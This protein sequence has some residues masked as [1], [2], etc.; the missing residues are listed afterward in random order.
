MKMKKVISLML[1]GAFML[2]SVNAVSAEEKEIGE[3]IN[4][5]IG[6]VGGDFENVELSGSTYYAPDMKAY[7]TYGSS[8]TIAGLGT[9][10]TGRSKLPIVVENGNKVF[11]LQPSSLSN[12]VGGKS[13]NNAFGFKL[14]TLADYGKIKDITGDVTVSFRMKVTDP[15]CLDKILLAVRPSHTYCG[16][17]AATTS[18]IGETTVSGSEISGKNVATY[19]PAGEWVNVELK[20]AKS[21][22]YDKADF[23]THTWGGSHVS[24]SS[25]HTVTA[26]NAERNPV[27]YVR[28]SFN[29]GTTNKSL[30]NYSIYLDDF[31]IDA[32]TSAESS[33]KELETNILKDVAW[34]KGTMGQAT[35]IAEETK[36]GYDAYRFDPAINTAISGFEPTDGNNWERAGQR[37]NV[38]ASVRNIKFDMDSWYKL[39][40]YVMVQDGIAANATLGTTADSTKTWVGKSILG[41]KLTGDPE[42]NTEGDGINTRYRNNIIAPEARTEWQKIELSFKPV[43]TTFNALQLNATSGICTKFWGSYQNMV[44][45]TYWVRKDIT[46]ERVDT[47]HIPQGENIVDMAAPYYLEMGDSKDTGWLYAN[48]GVYTAYPKQSGRPADVMSQGSTILYR[49]SEPLDSTKNYR[50]SFNIETDTNR[51]EKARVTFFT[52]GNSATLT[53]IIPEDALTEATEMVFDTRDLA[54]VSTSP[55][56]DLGDVTAIGIAIDSGAAMMDGAV[57]NDVMYEITNLK[58]TRIEPNLKYAIALSGNNAALKVTNETNANWSFKGRLFVAEYDENDCL[59]QIVAEDVDIAL[60]NGETISVDGVFR[61]ELTEGSTVKAFLWEPDDI[62]PIIE[63]KVLR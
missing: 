8:H 41:I 13:L 3:V 46:L 49:M 35:T 12:A 63:A 43:N 51:V 32:P 27:F 15:E 25:T 39:T 62:S 60:K 53:K 33:V 4:A 19:F 30:E 44:L 57:A 26:G 37:A 52:E 40:A 9:S 11:R 17:W 38:E 47:E 20:F 36:N 42:Q 22:F 28:P 18:K 45:P 48:N 29:Y 7:T 24:G 1:A 34:V 16:Q 54:S 56:V 5:D 58:I 23:A 50:I 2:G 55:L 59:L 6:F 61:R 14:V 31:A 10:T 21:T